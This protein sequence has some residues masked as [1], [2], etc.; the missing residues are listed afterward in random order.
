MIVG[1]GVHPHISLFIANDA[2]ADPVLTTTAKLGILVA[3]IIAGT[4]GF[5]LL[6]ST[7]SRY[8]ESSH[9]E[10]GAGHME[11]VPAGD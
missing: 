10:T 7:I 11:A 3:S 4:I 1:H 2:F 6:R 8:D 9:M 5:F